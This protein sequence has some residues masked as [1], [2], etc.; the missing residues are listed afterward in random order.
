MPGCTGSGASTA[1][2]STDA[3]SWQDSTGA[4]IGALD[5]D[6]NLSLGGYLLPGDT[7]ATTAG[8]IRYHSG[9]LEGYVSGSWQSL[10]AGAA[11]GEANTASNV[12]SAGVGL[13]KAKSSEDLQFYKILG[14]AGVSVVL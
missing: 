12:G 6:G 1:D 13:Y 7:A 8:S 14:S 3:Q 2:G 5:S 4:E 9:A 10:T 11:G